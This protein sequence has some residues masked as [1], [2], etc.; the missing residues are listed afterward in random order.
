MWEDPSRNLR[1]KPKVKTNKMK[2]KTKNETSA[3]QQQVWEDPGIFL[4]K[5]S[6][7]KR[8]NWK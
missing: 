6:K 8:K 3:G 1:K 7:V 4:R 2:L 5:K